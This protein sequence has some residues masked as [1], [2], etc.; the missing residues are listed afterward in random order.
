MTEEQKDI[1]R[2]I[3]SDMISANRD[4]IFEQ[5]RWDSSRGQRLA[6]EETITQCEE[7]FETFL[8]GL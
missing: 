5:H 7:A 4:A 1:L 8:E 2:D 3:V 6:A